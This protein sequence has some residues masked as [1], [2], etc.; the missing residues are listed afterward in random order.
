MQ[1]WWI[2]DFETDYTIK[3]FDARVLEIIALMTKIKMSD[4]ENK[5]NKLSVRLDKTLHL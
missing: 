3:L 4:G 2:F 5:S 1:C